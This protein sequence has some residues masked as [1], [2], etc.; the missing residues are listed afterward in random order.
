MRSEL[1]HIEG[2]LARLVWSAGCLVAAFKQ[3]S[4]DM[5]GSTISRG[6]LALEWTVCFGFLV[7]WGIGEI[8]DIPGLVAGDFEQTIAYL[9]YRGPLKATLGGLG[10]FSAGFGVL[11]LIAAVRYLTTGRGMRRRSLGPAIAVG[12]IVFGCVQLIAYAALGASADPVDL[13]RGFVL[14]A[15]LPAIGFV[16]LHHLSVSLPKVDLHG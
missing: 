6:V 5:S 2:D 9:S 11:G 7:A 13:A 15:L 16:H 3:R 12:L 14:M 1:A 8:V 10:F 4:Y